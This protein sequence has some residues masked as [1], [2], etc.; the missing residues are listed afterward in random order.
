MNC[1]VGAPRA[2]DFATGKAQLTRSTQESTAMT[3]PV[4]KPATKMKELVESINV[5]WT[6]QSF[7]EVTG[8]RLRREAESLA[9]VA[10]DEGHSVLGALAAMAWQPEEVHRHHRAAIA[11]SDCAETRAAYAY[12]LNVIA[13]PERAREEA[14]CAYK[15]APEDGARL[16]KAFDTA[17]I[18]GAFADASELSKQWARSFPD[19]TLRGADD[20]ESVLNAIGR[21]L[22]SV[23]DIQKIDDLAFGLCRERRIS[24]S[25]MSLSIVPPE[26]PE[27]EEDIISTVYLMTS[28]DTAVAM[29]MELFDR[30]ATHPELEFGSGRHFL[31]SFQRSDSYA[32]S[33]H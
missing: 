9:S 16:E 30:I 3:T 15:K 32:S 14:L 33:G 22:L 24:P 25:G 29:S 21:Q 19:R 31:V 27:D 4:R 17:V 7:D 2:R 10:P 1:A 6:T 13:E 26:G 20:I 28:T 11:A 8:R 23:E 18:A 5:L 12:S